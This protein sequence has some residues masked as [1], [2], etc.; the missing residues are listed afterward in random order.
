MFS[1]LIIKGVSLQKTHQ[2][3]IKKNIIPD[4]TVPSFP[5][6]HFIFTNIEQKDD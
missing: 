3:I 1:F 5:F 2:S 4:I 6:E